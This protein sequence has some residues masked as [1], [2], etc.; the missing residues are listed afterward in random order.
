ML[1]HSLSGLQH[2]G[3]HCFLSKFGELLME[4]GSVTFELCYLTLLFIIGCDV[5]TPGSCCN[6]LSSVS[7]ITP[8]TVVT[9]CRMSFKADRISG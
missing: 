4:R 2:F 3:R 5:A 9:Y 7:V 6:T 8:V 1:S